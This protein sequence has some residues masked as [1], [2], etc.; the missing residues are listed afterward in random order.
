MTTQSTR[1]LLDEEMP[2]KLGRGVRH[3][4]DKNRE[5]WTLMAPERVI[6]LDETAQEVISELLA[7]GQPDSLNQEGNTPDKNLS[8]G[9]VVDILAHRYDAPREDIAGDVLEMLQM[10]VDKKLLAISS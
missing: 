8:I 6:V 5:T 10:F 2:L 7:P 4:Y 9:K 3:Q 1:T